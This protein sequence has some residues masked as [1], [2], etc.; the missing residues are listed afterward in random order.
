MHSSVSL[1]I[2]MSYVMSTIPVFFCE[3]AIRLEVC[4]LSLQGCEPVK[5][6]E[7]PFLLCYRK[8]PHHTHDGHT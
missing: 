1:Y 2:I 5:D 4:V 6:Q 7:P 8:E 3:V